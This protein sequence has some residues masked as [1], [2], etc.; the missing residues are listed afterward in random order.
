M[1][2]LDSSPTFVPAQ[3]SRADG[4]QASVI[5]LICLG[6]IFFVAPRYGKTHLLVYISICSL[7]GGISVVCTQ[8]LGSSILTSIR[9]A[10]QFVGKGPFIYFLLGI[11]VSTLLVEIVFLN[12][13]LALFN[14]SLESRSSL[15]RIWL[16]VRLSR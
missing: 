8:G 7:I 13:A 1:C 11:V 3:E 14:T 16:I 15:R 9:G 5:I 10:N 4:V 12:K 2:L 6:L